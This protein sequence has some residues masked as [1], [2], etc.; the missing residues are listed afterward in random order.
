MYAIMMDKVQLNPQK[1]ALFALSGP[2]IWITL[3]LSFMVGKVTV[4]I[5]EP[6]YIWLT[7][8]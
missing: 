3:P 2:V 5:F 8:K 6:F 4:K 7:K 1:I